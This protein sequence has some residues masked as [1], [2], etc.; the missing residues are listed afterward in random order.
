MKKNNK[1]HL[2][3][4]FI[5][6]VSFLIRI[7]NIE[8][9]SLFGDELDVGYQAYSLL[10]NGHDYKGNFFPTYIQSLS[11][12]RAPL[13]IYTTIPTVALFGLNEM[14]VRLPPIIFGVLSIYF[15]YN[16]VLLLTNNYLLSSLTAF[17]LAVN[18]WHFHY[19]RTAFEVTLLLSLILLGSYFSYKF[20]N[21]SK[22]KFIYLAI[23]FFSLS[24]YTYNTANIFVP[25]IVL[26]IYFTN[27]KFFSSKINLKNFSISSLLF[28]ILVLPLIIQIFFGSAAN[29]FGLISIFKNQNLIDQIVTKRTTF[30][31]TSPNIE[32][33]FHNKPI[34][35]T[36]EFSKNY[37]SSLSLPFLFIYGDQTNLRHTIPGF[38]LVY[39][40]YLPFLLFGL[41]R[42]SNQDKLSKLMLYWLIFSPIASSLTISGGTHATRLFL[43]TVPLAYFTALGIQYILNY[44]NI[45]SRIFI[46]GCSII[47]LFQIVSYSH[48]YFVH[49]PKDSFEVWNY[50]YKELFSSIPATSNKVYISNA[51]YNSLLPYSFYQ[52]YSTNNNYLNDSN[53]E[54]IISNF[55]GFSLNQSVYFI[56][57]FKESDHLRAINNIAQTGNIFLLFQG[58]DIPGDMDFTV[59]SLDGYKTIKTVFNPNNTILGQVIQKI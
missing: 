46:F 30:S 31:A 55:S 8:N 10:Q 2:F 12:S 32:S 56:N 36:N 33:I 51:L 4:I 18:P 50:G 16:L 37:L 7:Y 29:R 44:K 53:Q 34:S 20:I 49:Y 57:D 26:F 13:L 9:L 40:I 23:L 48:E 58:Y 25:L 45:I 39:L 52:K 22:N 17:V 38:G 59:K 15:L 6:L 54:N 11:E 42:Y 14:G 35:W 43:M 28:F 47:L 24:F 41:F 21:Q 3:L 5:L 1:S 19:S 27:L